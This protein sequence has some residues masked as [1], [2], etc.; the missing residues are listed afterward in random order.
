MI[1]LAVFVSILDNEILDEIS[2][3]HI[4]F[5]TQSLC[6]PTLLVRY[7]ASVLA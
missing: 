1:C 3:R 7:F 5:V 6:S 4:R 2:N